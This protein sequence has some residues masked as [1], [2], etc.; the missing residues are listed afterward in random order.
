MPIRRPKH[1]TTSRNVAEMLLVYEKVAVCLEQNR[2]GLDNLE[3]PRYN[4]LIMRIR[5]RRRST[6]HSSSRRPKRILQKA[7]WQEVLRIAKMIPESDLHKLPTDLAE[8]H[9]HYLYGRQRG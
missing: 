4:D 3:D 7:V 1:H 5:S 9:D 6:R 8:K 2:T